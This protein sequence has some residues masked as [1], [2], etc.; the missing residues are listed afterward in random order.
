MPALSVAGLAH[1]CV[2]LGEPI[3]GAL[4]ALQITNPP[5]ATT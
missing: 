2:A 3:G 1:G 5:G 4:A